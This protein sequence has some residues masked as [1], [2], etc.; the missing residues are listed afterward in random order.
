MERLIDYAA[1]EIGIDRIELR[2]KNQIRKS[3]IPYK[4]RR[5]APPTTAATSRRS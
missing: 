3:E 5:P 2:R 4:V 1:A